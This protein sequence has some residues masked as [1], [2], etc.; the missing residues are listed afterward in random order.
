MAYPYQT[1]PYRRGSALSRSFLPLALITL[2]VV[3]LLGNLV[4]ERGRGGLLVLGLGA[5]FL[6]GRLTT[7]RYGYATPAGLLI[8]IGAFISLQDVRGITGIT[9]AGSF[10]ALLGLGFALVYA[11]GLRPWAVWPLFPAAVLVALG[12]LLMGVGSLGPLSSL[13]WIVAYWPVALV[14]LGVWLLLRDALPAPARRPI[15]TLGGLAL[16]AYGIIA[17]AAT[18][19][20]GGALARTGVAS[21]FGFGSSPFTDTVTLDQPI[22][23]G[24]TLA[25]NNTS[26]STT[27]HGGSGSTVHVVATRHYRFGGQPP[28]VQL[29]PSSSGLNLDASSRRGRFLFGDSSSVEYTIDLPA[30]VHVNVRSS[31]GGLSVSDV[32]GE[33]RLATSSGRIQATALPH[34]REASSS[35]G[36][37]SLQSVF[38]EQAQVHTSSGSVDL[39]LLP[40]SAVHLD[41]RT[42]SGS[43][44]PQ[45]GLFLT[46]GATQR[47][48]L[49]GNIGSPADGAVLSVQTSSGRVTISQ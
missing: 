4:P 15:A 13:T 47:N 16:L 42:S 11:I 10:F 28:E 2:G 26:G 25:V 1:D 32:T 19:A 7:G 3:F 9:S 39:R 27:I 34:L 40:G 22:S 23:P 41:V 43:V 21:G 37:I 8:A 38:T 17:A 36:D 44:V 12:L 45:G 48:S 29:T 30:G 20:A 35:S 24:Q 33:V 18:V 46:G 6:I 49:S 14:L 31:S 5:A